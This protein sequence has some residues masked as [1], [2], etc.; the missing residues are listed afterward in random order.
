MKRFIKALP[1]ALL[2]AL[3]SIQAVPAQ[4]VDEGSART[5]AENWIRTV[6]EYKGHWGE[7]KN[8]YVSQVSDFKR[9]DRVLG[10]FCL[11]EPSGHIVVSLLEGLAPIKAFSETSTLNP[12]SDEGPADL[13]KLQME[14]I[15]DGIEKRLGPISDITFS[16]LDTVLALNHYDTWQQLKSGP[17]SITGKFNPSGSGRDYEEGQELLTSR[18]HQRWPYNVLCPWA[19]PGA[20]CPNDDSLC[21][22]G[23]VATA[24]AQIM[25][26]WSWPPGRD[27]PNMPD[28]M[29]IN[30]TQGEI[31]A[32][33]ELCWAVGDAV[34]MNWCVDGSCGSSVPTSEMQG[35]YKSWFYST[36]CA[37]TWRYEWEWYEWYQFIKDNLNQ[38]RPIQY[39]V[40]K[41]SIVC[42]GWWEAGGPQYHMNYGWANDY[43]NWYMV[44]HLHQPG[45]GS[46]DN[47]YMIHN[48]YPNCALGPS[49]SGTYPDNPAYPHRFVDRD[50]LAHS[51]HFEAGQLIHFHPDKTMKCASGYLRID[52]EPALHTRLYTSD[53]GRGVRIE[54]GSILMY[55][56]GGIRL[57][58]RRPD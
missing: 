23:C 51:V 2:I 32:V 45:G 29:L 9:G 42:D 12:A 17:L 28:E 27:W 13:L 3:I 41:H 37:W 24:G 46:P 30:P 49:I 25:R 53:P 19:P 14:R 11:V 38:N 16:D 4:T 18:W 7:S 26:Y 15:L 56:G 20:G 10:Y 39:R 21:A 31:N 57:R 48:I 50:C 43:N 44:D 35:V 58:L 8:A 5:I 6:I 47:E 54:N 22:V 34:G 40:E 1:S 55:E 33:S 52:G 36:D